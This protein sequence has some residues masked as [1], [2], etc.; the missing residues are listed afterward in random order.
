MIA[1][2]ATGTGIATRV[3][4]GTDITIIIIGVRVI[5]TGTLLRDGTATGR[6]PGTGNVAAA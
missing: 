5:D 6:D 1:G 3:G 4:T 2:I